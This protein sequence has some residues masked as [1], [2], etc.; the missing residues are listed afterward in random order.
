MACKVG[1]SAPATS[2]LEVTDVCPD[3]GPAIVIRDVLAS[4]QVQR[5]PGLI[6]N[7]N[8]VAAGVGNF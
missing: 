7:K 1:P 4:W 6:C 3:A 5:V 8:P 2:S